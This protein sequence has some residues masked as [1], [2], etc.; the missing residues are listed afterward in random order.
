VNSH[1]HRPHSLALHTHSFS[2]TLIGAP[3]SPRSTP[4]NASE[5]THYPP[6]STLL[7]WAYFVYGHAAQFL[8]VPI[9]P[10]RPEFCRVS[11]RVFLGPFCPSF[12]DSLFVSSFCTLM[13]RL[14]PPPPTSLLCTVS[15]R[16]FNY[17]STGTLRNL[18][19][20][21][22]RL[23]SFFLPCSCLPED[24][25]PPHFTVPQISVL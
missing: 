14:T 9:T 15:W 5:E 7:S 23:F 25:P 18:L 4:Q 13:A 22:A 16:C 20:F 17:P 6:S 2:L 12:F 1:Q 8:Q 3:C 11:H 21:F 10:F 19:S 24:P